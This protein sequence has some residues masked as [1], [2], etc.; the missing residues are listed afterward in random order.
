MLKTEKQSPFYRNSEI[1]HCSFAICL[2]AFCKLS[3]VGDNKKR[4]RDSPSNAL[5]FC[6]L[7]RQPE[8]K[9]DNNIIIW[10]P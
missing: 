5:I 4:R 2:L 9:V 8:E 1:A 7:Q 10:S 3:L 6:L